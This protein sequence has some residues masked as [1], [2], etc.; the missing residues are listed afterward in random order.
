[1][2][3]RGLAAGWVIA[4]VFLVQILVLAESAHGGDDPS[5]GGSV[6]KAS[7]AVGPRVTLLSFNELATRLS[8]GKTRLL[9]CRAKPDYDAGHIPGAIWVDAKAVE[10]MAAKPGALKDAA[11]WEEWLAPLGIEPGMEVFCYDSNRQLDAAR[12][13]FLLRYLGVD[14]A[15][16][17]NGGFSLWQKEG[18]PVSTAKAKVAPRPRPVAFRKDR[19]AERAD[20]LGV[21][22]DKSARILD[23]RSDG[24]HLGT[25]KRSKQAGRVPAACHLEWKSLV[26]DQGRFLPA[27]E[28]RAKVSSAGIK[29]GEAVITHCQGGGRASVNAFALELVGIRARNYYLGWSDWGNADA[30]PIESGPPQPDTR[31]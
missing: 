15:G 8:D 20:V 7:D 3:T 16:L 22:N 9:D 6:D 21:L 27:S 25:E 10:A 13:W 11:A 2:L 29:P 12:V 23:A 5:A 18:R 30:V 4:A 28:L 19:L 24:E 1:M 31:P 14:D 26:D 17:V